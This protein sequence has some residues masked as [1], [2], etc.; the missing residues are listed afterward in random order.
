[1]KIEIRQI[2]PIEL[3]PKAWNEFDL[4]SAQPANTTYYGALY[5]GRL[6]STPLYLEACIDGEKVS[7]W[8]LAKNRSRRNPLSV[9]LNSHC[10]PQ[11]KQAA[12][13]HYDDIFTAYLEFMESA[14]RP[15]NITVLSYALTRGIPES[16]LRRGGFQHIERFCTYLNAL[17]DDAEMLA[18]FHASHRNDTRRAIREGFAYT[19]TLS[20]EEYYQLS[21]ETYARSGQ[22]GPSEKELRNIQERMVGH[23]KGIISGVKVKGVLAAASVVLYHACYAVYLYGASSA[24]KARGATTLIHYENM[25][26]LRERGVSFYDFGGAR[27]GDDLEG[28][29][30]SISAFKARFGGR[31]VEAYGGTYR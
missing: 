20:I 15:Q 12:S 7:Q 13:L 22:P 9:T 21:K 30:L 26:F 31:L 18:S 17:G 19:P 8:L 14:L 4:A 5:R 23:G 2:N 24:S 27:L 29:A 3:D 10:G 28:K 11:V 6:L 1:M 25:K 16:A